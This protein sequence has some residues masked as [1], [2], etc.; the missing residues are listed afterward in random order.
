[1]RSTFVSP[2]R[3]RR[4]GCAVIAA[5]LAVVLL[6]ALLG[7]ASW[8][9]L[10]ERRGSAPAAAELFSDPLGDEDGYI[11]EGES[12][13]PFADDLP[14][15]ARLDPAL[16]A[17]VQAAATDAAADDVPFVVTSGW[18]SERYQQALVDDA[19]RE[20]GAEEAG[21]RVAS[22]TSSA[23]LTGGAVDIGY[24]DADSWLAQHGTD[25]GL[26]QIYANEIWHFELATEP[27]G[28]CPEQLP[29]ASAT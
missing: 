17:A 10:S 28:D 23:H 4:V 25:Y 16:R 14:A 2:H 13:S 8:A 26:C 21:R 15:I 1:M 9:L 18:R 24:T 19:V 12:V 22:V 27:G 20:Y 6:A 3:P 7:A 5:S 29:D 11:E